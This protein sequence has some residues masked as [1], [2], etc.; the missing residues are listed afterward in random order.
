MRLG[1]RA[2]MRTLDPARGMHCGCNTD[3]AHG[4]SLQAA[5]MP[6]RP[7]PAPQPARIGRRHKQA[8]ERTREEGLAQL[9]NLQAKR[10]VLKLLLHLAPRE[11]AQVAAAAGRAAVALARR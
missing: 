3:R 8:L 6:L 11:E 5:R 1:L 9:A 10:R 2:G 4:A 7:P